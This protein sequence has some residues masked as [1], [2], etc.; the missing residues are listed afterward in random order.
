MGTHT[1][2]SSF[3]PGGVDGWRGTAAWKVKAWLIDEVLAAQG[4][5]SCNQFV[6]IDCRRWETSEDLPTCVEAALAHLK[7]SADD[8]DLGGGVV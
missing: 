1:S 2:I 4:I 5:Q 6:L 8:F 3:L 7:S